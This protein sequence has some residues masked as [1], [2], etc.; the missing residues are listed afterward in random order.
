MPCVDMQGQEDEKISSWCSS[1]CGYT[2]TCVGDFWSLHH[3]SSWQRCNSPENWREITGTY[4]EKK[5]RRYRAR[6]QAHLPRQLLEARVK[7]DS[8]STCTTTGDSKAVIPLCRLGLH[9]VIFQVKIKKMCIWSPCLWASH[10][11]T[12]AERWMRTPLVTG[13]WSCPYGYP[14]AELI[15]CA[16]ISG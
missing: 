9:T 6:I 1:K 4:N 12:C 8:C 3:V 13:V 11:E 7:P 5:T 2:L 10:T 15:W 16:D 14:C